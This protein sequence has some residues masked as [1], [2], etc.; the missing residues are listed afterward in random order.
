MTSLEETVFECTRSLDFRQGLAVCD[1]ALKKSGL[2]KEEFARRVL[3]FRIQGKRGS[4]KTE[5]PLDY[6]DARSGSVAESIAR[7]I[8]IEN[9]Y[10]L[11]E[12]QVDVRG[13]FKRNESYR[14]DFLWLL[15]DGTRVA[16]EYSDPTRPDESEGSGGM[17][18]ADSGAEA[19]KRARRRRSNGVTLMRFG[20]MDLLSDRRFCGILD[21]Y[22]IPCEG[23]RTG[24]MALKEA[25]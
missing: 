11:P 6:M 9:L 17:K 22:G 3:S 23:R 16:G 2:G 12:L 10:Q 20:P 21:E 8:M 13:L 1:C 19:K 14:V 18:D 5:Y 15:P 7:A 4:W 25:A 24:S